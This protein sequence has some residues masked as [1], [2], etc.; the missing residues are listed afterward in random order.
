MLFAEI[1][2]IFAVKNFVPVCSYTHLKNISTTFEKKTN[3]IPPPRNHCP[4]TASALQTAFRYRK[5]S[6]KY[7]E[8]LFM[9]KTRL[10]RGTLVC[11]MVSKMSNLRCPMMSLKKSKISDFSSTT[12]FAICR[13]HPPIK[14]GSSAPLSIARNRPLKSWLSAVRTSGTSTSKPLRRCGSSTKS[15]SMPPSTSF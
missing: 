13:T 8:V 4:K 15:T 12:Y 1:Q 5:A 9:E 14:F 6:F 11:R 3:S 7:C 10:L 2:L